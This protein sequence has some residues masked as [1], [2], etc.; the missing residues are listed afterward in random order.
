MYTLFVNFFFSTLVKKEF[1]SNTL[2]KFQRSTEFQLYDF[3]L[4]FVST[5]IYSNMTYT[6]HNYIYSINKNASEN[7]FFLSAIYNYR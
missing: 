2:S 1:G 5:N 6:I 3:T 7:L 4:F